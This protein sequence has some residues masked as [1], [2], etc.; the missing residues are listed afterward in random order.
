MEDQQIIELCKK[1]YRYLPHEGV[2]VN[3]S[4]NKLLIFSEESEKSLIIHQNKKISINLLCFILFY[5]LIPPKDCIVFNRD[6]NPLNISLRNLK[7]ISRRD[8]M[9]IQRLLRNARKYLKLKNHPEDRYKVKVQWLDFQ[10]G[11]LMQRSFDDPSGAKT[12]IRSKMKGLLKE[13][14]TL[15]VDLETADIFINK[16]RL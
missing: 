14:N 15:G 9:K 13:L 6:L 3:N 7:L 12:F 2:L 11:T 1:K 10:K 4:T 5:G 16:P 8:Y